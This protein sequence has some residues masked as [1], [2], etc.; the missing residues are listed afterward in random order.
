MMIIVM[1]G[2]YVVMMMLII[3]PV[4][5]LFGLDP[6]QIKEKLG[7]RLMESRW[8]GQSETTVVTLTL[9]QVAM[10]VVVFMLR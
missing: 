3:M 1:P 8:G 10:P 2:V 7:S 4:A 9:E 5:Y 6:N